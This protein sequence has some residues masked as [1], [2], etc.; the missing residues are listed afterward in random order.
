MTRRRRFVLILLTIVL[1]PPAL[2]ALNGLVLADRQSPR[3]RHLDD[4]IAS[5]SES[6]PFLVTIASYNIAK[7]FVHKG[8]VS[9]DSRENVE[10]RLRA[11]AGAIKAE[12]P[13]IVFLSEAITECAPC[14]VDQVAFLA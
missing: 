10:T 11:M 2:F 3:V 8:G 12:K 9:F 6:G 5:P 4:V 1:M 13:D 14:N 7:G